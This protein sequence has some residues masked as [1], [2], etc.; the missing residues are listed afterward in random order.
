MT[1][2]HHSL[3][4]LHPIPRSG[5][6]TFHPYPSVSLSTFSLPPTN[7]HLDQPPVISN[8]PI[9]H[10]DGRHKL[11]VISPAANNHLSS[12]AAGT[13]HLS[14]RLP[15]PTTCHR[16]RPPQT[17]CHLE[18]PPQTT[19]HLERPIGRR[20]LFPGH[21][22]LLRAIFTGINKQCFLQFDK[23]ALQKTLYE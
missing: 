17:T 7:C 3:L 21:V 1:F 23:I 16:E 11:P 22:Q 2:F 10:L 14:S 5:L 19:C 9:C 15:L 4:Q 8:G 12:R 20:D 6:C 18:W 13:N